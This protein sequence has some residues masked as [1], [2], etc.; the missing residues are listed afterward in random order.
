MKLKSITSIRKKM[1]SWARINSGRVDLGEDLLEW[2]LEEKE[3]KVA[4]KQK[5][6]KDRR[7]REE[8]KLRA[9]NDAL[10]KHQKGE[11]LLGDEMKILLRHVQLDTDPKLSSKVED[12]RTLWDQRKDRLS[13]IASV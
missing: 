10:N 1:T 11:R 9:L 8:K 4:A 7:S 13:D 3:A 5:K 6:D 12:L 2:A